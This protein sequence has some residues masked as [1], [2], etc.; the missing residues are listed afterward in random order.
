MP[1]LEILELS[2]GD[3]CVYCI[4]VWDW[5]RKTNFFHLFNYKTYA[6]SNP[7]KMSRKNLPHENFAQKCKQMMRKF[8]K[9]FDNFFLKALCVFISEQMLRKFS[10]IF[11]DF[12]VP[13]L[14]VVSAYVCAGSA[15][16]AGDA[17]VSAQPPLAPAAKV[18]LVAF[19]A[20]GAVRPVGP[21][22]ARRALRAPEARR[23]GPAQE[24]LVARADA[25]FLA[26]QAPL[27]HLHTD[28]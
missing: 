12:F 3:R 11:H 20:L 1:V 5:E 28:T 27:A 26:G 2:H 8:L 25:P 4:V 23:A 15:L 13:A 18:A 19:F 24:A 22:V 6:K 10:K 21:H 14:C 7:E 16:E 9:R 17:H